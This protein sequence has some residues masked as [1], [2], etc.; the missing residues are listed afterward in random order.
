MQPGSCGGLPGSV[1]LSTPGRE[2]LAAALEARSWAGIALLLDEAGSVAPSLGGLEAAL[3]LAQ[4]LV[5][6]ATKEPLPL[7]VRVC[8]VVPALPRAGGLPASGAAHGGSW[9]FARV[10]RL[11][12]PAR[13]ILSLDVSAASD[14]RHAARALLAESVLS[15]PCED[16]VAWV[17]RVRL[18]SLIHI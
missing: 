6:S 14:T 1:G 7:V 3:S 13:R 18:L 12:Q 10:L 11:E 17:R 16:E 5:R 8:G 2:P 9:G 4:Q 15:R